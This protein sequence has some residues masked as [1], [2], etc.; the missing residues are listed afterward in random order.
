MI[1]KARHLNDLPN[2]DNYQFYGIEK[3]GTV[4]DC[5]V[6]KD[7]KGLHRVTGAK[8]TDLIAWLPL[9]YLQNSDYFT[10]QTT[11]TPYLLNL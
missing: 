4:R 5:T 8:F 11:I 3:D 7:A 2:T 1:H 10:P 9:N 6:T